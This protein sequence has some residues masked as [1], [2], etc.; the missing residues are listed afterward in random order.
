MGQCA[1]FESMALRS[2]TSVETK[3]TQSTWVLIPPLRTS[4][5]NFS[6]Q[7]AHPYRTKILRAMETVLSSHIHDLDKDT[8][9]AVILL[10]TSEM[11]RTKVRASGMQAAGDG[12]FTLTSISQHLERGWSRTC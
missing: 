6:P 8:A 7:L 12:S 2:A 3:C 11:T 9:G 10:A 1:L 5:G 4:P